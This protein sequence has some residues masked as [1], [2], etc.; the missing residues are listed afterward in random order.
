MR[1]RELVIC[2]S[3]WSPDEVKTLRFVIIVL[4]LG[5]ADG[6]TLLLASVAVG[7]NANIATKNVAA[8]VAMI[9][10][11]NFFTITFSLRLVTP[12]TLTNR[13]QT[14]NSAIL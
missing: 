7:S 11:F 5:E 6:D 4:G 13:G 8:M 9:D 10:K 1:L 12:A 3:G 2:S 14:C